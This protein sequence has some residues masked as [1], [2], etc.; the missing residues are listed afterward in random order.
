MSK[1]ILMLLAAAILIAGGAF[2]AEA[3][4][5]PQ[6]S[7][8]QGVTVTATLQPGAASGQEWTVAVSLQTHAH[9]LNERL[10]S[11]SELI[12]DGKKY[13][14]LGW[15]G[16]PPG[17]HHRKGV[18]RFPAISPQP[19]TV[20]LKIRLNGEGSPRSFRWTAK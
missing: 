16:A 4:Y 11:V 7:N 14:P 10:E 8:E 2:A 19:S 3:A 1:P 5:P 6:T 20:E 13:A 17:G 15:E 9:P 18:L 12:A